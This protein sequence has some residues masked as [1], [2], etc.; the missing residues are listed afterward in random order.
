MESEIVKHNRTSVLLTI[1][2]GMVIHSR[3]EQSDEHVA[4]L[5]AWVWIAE[6][7]GYKVIPPGDTKGAAHE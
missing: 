2:N 7:A 6:S 4:S 3:T 1:E 5:D